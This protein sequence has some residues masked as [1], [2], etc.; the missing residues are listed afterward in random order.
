MK[1]CPACASRETKTKLD[2]IDKGKFK[3]YKCPE[4]SYSLR[5]PNDNENNTQ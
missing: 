2:V 5:V 1:N 4:C 3:V